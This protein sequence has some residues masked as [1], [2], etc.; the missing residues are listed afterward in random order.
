MG[1]QAETELQA[2]CKAV[3]PRLVKSDRTVACF[4]P[5]KVCKMNE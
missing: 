2:E 3:L 4:Q 1:N 5:Q